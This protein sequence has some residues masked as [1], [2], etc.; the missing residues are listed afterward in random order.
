[1]CSAGPAPARPG[2]RPPRSRSDPL[3]RRHARLGVLEDHACAAGT[4]SA[5]AA[6]R[7]VSGAGLP[8]KARSLATTPSIGVEQALDAR[9]LQDLLGLALAETIAVAIPPAR[10]ALM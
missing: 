4:P 6:A 3:A 7:K 8:R 1:M 10:T 5:S 2:R 9:G